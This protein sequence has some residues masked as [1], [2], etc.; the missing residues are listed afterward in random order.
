MTFYSWAALC[1]LLL[2]GCSNS[3]DN[4]LTTSEADRL[5]ER[6]GDLQPYF[7]KAGIQ[8]LLDHEETGSPVT[9][10]QLMSIT[11]DRAFA[12]YEAEA[13][14]L[15]QSL[16]VG[17]RFRSEIFGQLIGS[18]PL[19]QTRIIEFSSMAVLLSAVDTPAYTDLMNTL[20]SASDDHV[21]LLGE[22]LPLP[23]EPMGSYFDP[24]L[25]N[26][27]DNTARALLSGAADITNTNASSINSNIEP[28]IDMLTSDEPGP[29]WMVNLIDFYE[30]AT[31]PDGRETNLTGEEANTIY[32][33]AIL[34][35]L[36][37]FNSL[38]EFVMTVS[39][40]LT[41]EDV[42]WEQV[43]IPRYASRDAFLNS[44]A[45]NP[46]APELLVFKDA[47]VKHTLVYPSEVPGTAVPAPATG[48][49]FDFRYCEVLLFYPTE[50]GLR[51]D[52]YNSMPL[53]DCP[54]DLWDALDADQIASDYG[55][56][57]AGLNGIRFW[58][59]DDIAGERPDQ[60][61]I[62]NFG[63][64]QM[65]LAASVAVAPDATERGLPGPYKINR[66][67]RDTVFHYVA[68]RQV[69]ELEDADGTRYRMQSFTQG[70]DP[71]QQLIDLQRLGE[72]LDLP[73]GWSFHVVLL[74]ENA[75][76]ATLDGI[77]EVITDD[78]GNTYQ[79][80]D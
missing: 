34:P 25:Q 27:D 13:A 17:E 54:S 43:A 30:N 33:N 23:F 69:Y 62:E 5:L 45:F 9:L 19:N 12:R 24:R 42:E 46:G 51:A 65:R 52:V 8:G 47:G 21:W 50:A 55:A 39:S 66:V 2:T 57:A 20:A 53:S 18:R 72:R 3:S 73:Q 16:G 7:T 14:A 1:L 28:I 11:D 75:A 10:V 79:R 38:P 70:Q 80:T 58:V 49:L 59:L 44:F 4:S 41:D 76:L 40:T 22:E 67:S 68:G 26:I 32:S 74:Q 29:F 78:F 15:W 48:P 31:F 37:R 36:V 60:P 71:D 63:G 56:Q 61:V 35:N 64:I 6:F 77:A